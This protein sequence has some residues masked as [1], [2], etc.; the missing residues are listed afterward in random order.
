MTVATGDT[1]NPRAYAARSVELLQVS[2]DGIA[3]QNLQFSGKV[4]ANTGIF[5][6]T[7]PNGQGTLSGALTLNGRQAG[8]FFRAP[9]NNGSLSGATLWGR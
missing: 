7:G 2:A 3:T 9:V 5:L 8:Y 4:D 1:S 6:G